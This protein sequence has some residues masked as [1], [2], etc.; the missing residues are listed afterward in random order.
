MTGS[1]LDTSF[2]DPEGVLRVTAD[3]LAQKA[4]RDL[5]ANLVDAYLTAGPESVCPLHVLRVERQPLERDSDARQE[6][7]V[8]A[9][10]KD[11][12]QSVLIGEDT[13]TAVVGALELMHEV[14]AE[15]SLRM[16][17]MRAELAGRSSLF[18]QAT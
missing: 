1:Y 8:A 3:T 6:Y 12:E 2:H 18:P 4:R 17:L 10:E 5:V 7:R 14:L 11:T 9:A 15:M 13:D 16:E